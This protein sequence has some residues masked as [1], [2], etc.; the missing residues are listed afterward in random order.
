M[1]EEPN[2]RSRALWQ[3][4]GCTEPKTRNPILESV[5]SAIC[6]WKYKSSNETKS[7]ALRSCVFL[8]FFPTHCKYFKIGF[9][10]H[11]LKRIQNNIHKILLHKLFAFLIPLL[12]LKNIYFNMKCFYILSTWR[13]TLTFASTT[14]FFISTLWS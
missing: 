10:P 12:S 13:N 3:Y 1:E 4:I 2:A 5:L 7:L 11:D 14:S 6:L 8:M 9:F